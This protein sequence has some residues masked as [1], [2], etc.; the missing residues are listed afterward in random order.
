[1]Y[2]QG[3]LSE[4]DLNVVQGINKS[5]E[6]DIPRLREGEVGGVFWSVYVPC[7][8]ENKVINYITTLIL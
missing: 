8:T 3:Q 1:M 2:K 4:V 5:Q 6:T 7:S